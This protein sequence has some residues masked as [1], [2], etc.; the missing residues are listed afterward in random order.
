L[1]FKNLRKSFTLKWIILYS[2]LT[3]FLIGISGYILIKIYQGNLKRS[4]IEIQNLEAN[5]IAERVEDFFKKIENTLLLISENKEFISKS[6][7][8]TKRELENLLYLTDYFSEISL[9]NSQG[10]EFIRISYEKNI[11]PF[12]VVDRSKSEIFEVAS[13]GKIYYGDFYLTKDLTP[14]IVIGVPF[15]KLKNNTIAGV[16]V[17]KVKLK[18]LWRTVVQSYIETKR[19]I[20]II[21]EKGRLIAHSNPMEVLKQLDIEGPSFSTRI[22]EKTGKFFEVQDYKGTKFSTVVK[23]IHPTG[24]RLII[25]NPSSELFKPI[26]QVTLSFVQAILITLIV[27]IFLSLF[28]LRRMILPIKQLSNEMG[29]VSKGNL[30]IYIKPKTL[31][32]I[33]MLTQ[34][35][36]LMVQE[37]KQSQ[38]KFKTIFDDSKDMIFIVSREGKFIDINQAGLE[39]FGFE[40]KEDLKEI[41]V[42]DTFLDPEDHKRFMDE[43]KT[44]MYIKDFEVKLKKRNGNP[45]DVLLTATMMKDD[46]GN[47]I[48]Y[49]GIIKDITPRKKMEEEITEQAKE[50]KILYELSSLIN[51]SLD[52]DTVLQRSLEKVA[53]TMGFNIGSIFL[54]H[55]DKGLL[56]MKYQ[57]GHTDS[58]L[59]G[60]KYFKYGE[61]VVGKAIELRKILVSKVDEFPPSNLVPLLKEQGIQTIVGIPLLQKGKII[62]AISLLSHSHRNLSEREINLLESIANQ[63]GLNLENVRLFSETL[64]AKSEWEATFDAVTDII[65]IRDKDY[66][67]IRAN[68]MAYERLGFKPDEIIGKRCFEVFHKMDRPCDECYISDVLKNKNPIS[69]ER[70]REE[71]NGIFKHFLFPIK[72]HEDNLLGVVEIT[73]EI[74]EERRKEN[75]KE[76]LNNVNK[77]LASGFNVKQTVKAIFNELKKIIEIQRMSISLF[78]ESKQEFKVFSLEKDYD[79]TVIGEG[80]THPIKGTNFERVIETGLPL[81][82]N[83]TQ[84]TDSRVGKKLLEEGIRSLLNIPL[85]YQGEIIGTLNLGSKIKNAFSEGLFDLLNPIASGLGIFMQN[86]LLIEEIK[87]SEENYRTVVEG[88]L[89]GVGVVGDDYKFKYVNGKLAEIQGYSREELI[90]KDIRDFIDEESKR[91]L[92]DRESQRKKGIKVSP[93]FELTIVRKN[94][95][96]RYVEISARRIKDQKGEFNIIIILKD[97]TEKKRMEEQLIQS[98]KLRALGEMASG[99]AHEFNNALA[100]I[101]GNTQLL[102]YT[103]QDDNIKESLKIIEKVAKDSAHIV[104]RLQDFTR[105]RNGE[106]VN[107][108]NVNSIILDAIEMTKPKWKNDA[109]VKGINIELVSNLRMVSPV[110]GHPSELREVILNMIFNAIE[111]M[112]EGG[113]IEIKTFEKDGNVFIQIS[114]TGIGMSE[115]VKKKIFEPFFTTKPF[116]NTGLGLSMAYG[117]IKRFGGEISVESK[118][119]FG[120]TFTIT[121]PIAINH[122]K[123]I[124][125][126]ESVSKVKKDGKKSRVLVIDDEETVRNVIGKALLQ[127]NHEVSLA[128]DGEEGLKL[129]QEKGFDLVLTD[130]GM[131]GISGWDVGKIIKRIDPKVKIGMIT[132]WGLEINQEK[133]KEHGID[134]LIA[135]PFEIDKIL[136][137]ISEYT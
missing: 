57:F 80:T 72:D 129:F 43:I 63:I 83:D 34:S 79:F 86:A 88:A 12:E 87:R 15:G 131:P 98:E 36:N 10:K 111:A 68:K 76:V 77:I 128:K 75:E 118:V 53:S 127:G 84:N 99:V 38:D 107:Q 116:T 74:T 126:I 8:H 110:E 26:K 49:H 55:E 130:L 6:P 62:G 59:K 96:K 90:G 20:Y 89:D 69:I 100:A 94:G 11:K 13:K 50:L 104:R 101:L 109:Q 112:P 40:K 92:A 31:D 133:M 42:K 30:N 21:D 28:L 113:K 39:L 115:E 45:L 85:F 106:K 7:S 125:K 82:I 61:G 58:L 134:F 5:F 37:L 16:I 73:R 114:D 22:L 56:E 17:G 117:I 64:K 122:Q 2:F 32:E 14:F 47:I 91:L 135:K 132:G 24:W 124:Q 35:F 19:T 46:S 41:Y 9:L 18:N 121:L 93:H 123:E 78:D 60:A 120:S 1:I 66:R 136:Q 70:V 52:I 102:L 27:G 4:I 25:Q 54:F 71:F 81:I 95:E 44:K 119:G 105:K 3:A 108:I 65:L 51:Q 29:K 48:N 67:I 137:T 103:A 33:G 97:I 23:A